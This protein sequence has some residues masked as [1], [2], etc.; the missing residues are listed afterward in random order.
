[1]KELELDLSGLMLDYHY[2]KQNRT[3]VNNLNAAL[4]KQYNA[5]YKG[6]LKESMKLEKLVLQNLVIINNIAVV[7]QCELKFRKVE[8]IAAKLKFDFISG[9]QKGFNVEINANI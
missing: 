7:H 3:F 1:M 6:N 5:I 8:K 4:E 2:S 9:V